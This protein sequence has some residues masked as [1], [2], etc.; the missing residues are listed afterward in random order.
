MKKILLSAIAVGAAIGFTACSSEEPLG[1]NGDGTGNVTIVANLPGGMN[2]RAFSDGT[3][4]TTLHYYIY[5]KGATTPVIADTKDINIS[6]T[7]NLSLVNG[8]TYD[9]VFW[10][11]NDE[12]GVYEYDAEL[13][14]ITVDY[15]GIT[16]NEENRDAFYCVKTITVT[17]GT[18]ETAELYRPFAQVNFGTGDAEEAAAISVYGT[19][20]SEL[21]TEL[22]VATELPNI[23]DLMTGAVSG[24]VN[25]TFGKGGVPSNEV[26]PANQGADNPLSAYRYV[27]MDYILCGAERSVVDLSLNIYSGD[28]RKSVVQ[29][30]NA[31][32]QANYQ[33]NIYGNLLTS[34]AAVNVIIIPA[35][36]DQENI[37]I[38]D[39]TAESPIVDDAAKT[40]TVSNAAQ[41]AGFANLVNAGNGYKGYTV[42]L[43]SDIDL[44]NTP[45]EPIAS[46][47]GNTSP[48][49]QGVF[50]GG[51]HTVTGLNV[52]LEG[53]TKSA[54]L[55][56]KVPGTI[57]NL[58][59]RD[60]YVS[61][62]QGNDSGVGVGI[63]AGKIY[64][65]GV[66][67]NCTV[68]NS[69]V[70]GD[71]C[72]GGIV[73]YAYGSINNCTLSDSNVSANLALSNADLNDNAGGIVGYIGEGNYTVNNNKVTGCTL[74][75]YR[76]VGGIA[77]TANADVTVTGNTISNTSIT[78]TCPLGT[79]SSNSGA[80]SNGTVVGRNIKAK[81]SDN[82]VGDDVTIGKAGDL[83]GY[84]GITVDAN[85]ALRI[86]TPQGLQS[87]A[88]YIT[89]KTGQLNDAFILDADIDAS[90]ITW[91]AKFRAGTHLY[92]FDGNGHT[93]SNLN[94]KDGLFSGA[95]SGKSAPTQIKN[96]T[97]KNCNVTGDWAVGTV[98]A[99]FYGC[100]ELT[101]VH[102]ENCTVN[103]DCQVG[104]FV[105]AL[106]EGNGSDYGVKFT[107]CTVKNTSITA[108]G[109]T[110]LKAGASQFVGF[111]DYFMDNEVNRNGKYGVKYIEFGEGNSVYN[112][113]VSNAAS[114]TGGG[115]YT[116]GYIKNEN[117]VSNI[118]F[119]L[120]SHNEFI[121]GSV[122]EP[123]S[124]NP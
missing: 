106:G 1:Q 90:G 35:F 34:S 86:S 17:G 96:V 88:N 114:M 118:T 92:S 57:K 19:D 48:G 109:H 95:A 38:W 5:E 46:D 116:I 6:T 8:M 37:E 84:P 27:S 18:T 111:V 52:R 49:F 63:V 44:N 56:G 16:Q 29:V 72:V 124:D 60:S 10:A 104:G 103:G 15:E 97:F 47:T 62:N 25:V 41:L 51:N 83:T 32:I 39:G 12:A 101:N 73:G 13:R 23:I 122:T 40:V 66:I 115:I 85:G 61:L 74:I 100:A 79:T 26:F 76:K 20:L 78:F 65:S 112:N 30:P 102:L 75:A 80:F 55:F 36:N 11:Q 9:M 31:P 70:E 110:T 50:D 98:F 33:T 107:N 117:G 99:Y 4:A 123:V 42:T 69:T 54:G 81:V 43:T 68:S 105:G 3:T 45:W 21:Q 14:T 94:I 87:F 71:H 82:T 113:T 91:A 2:T 89:N 119:D 67:E 59:I 64:P 77:G 108:K 53:A 93:I 28:T 7:L 120:V 24:A 58:N 121:N 22:V